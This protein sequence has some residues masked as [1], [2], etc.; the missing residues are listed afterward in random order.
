MSD[1]LNVTELVRASLDRVRKILNRKSKENKDHNRQKPLL[2]SSWGHVEYRDTGWVRFAVTSEEH[3]DIFTM[4]LPVHCVEADL[5][6]RRG[7][8]RVFDKLLVTVCKALMSHRPTVKK[9]FE[10]TWDRKII[11][12]SRLALLPNYSTLWEKLYA[13]KQHLF[14]LSI[15]KLAI[16]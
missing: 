10:L 8:V 7:I 1:S 5:D 16:P 6:F 14:R 2:K 13:L 4:S 12:L 11:C 3:R 9:V 15:S